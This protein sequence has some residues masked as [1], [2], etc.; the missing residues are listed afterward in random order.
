MYK[1]SSSKGKKPKYSTKKNS[2]GFSYQDLANWG[3][4]AASPGE[5]QAAIDSQVGAQIAGSMGAGVMPSVSGNPTIGHI[6]KN[7]PG[8][9]GPKMRTAPQV[10]MRPAPQIDPSG[11]GQNSGNLLDQL[12]QSMLSDSASNNFDYEAALQQSQNAIRQAYGAEIAAIRSNNNAARKDTRKARQE[13]EHMY[14]GLA[15]V[16]GQSAN[17]A[18]A[19]GNQGAQAA[20]DL[21]NQTNDAIVNENSKVTGQEA[22]ML[23]DLGLQATADQVI[24]PDYAKMKQVT[25]DVSKKGNE[26]AQFQK[27]QGTINRDYFQRGRTGVVFEGK[28][29]QA[30]LIAQLQDYLRQNRNQ[31]GTL[32]GQRAKELANNKLS[33]QQSIASQQAQADQQMWQRLMDYANLKSQIE[34]TNI[35]NTLAANK[36][37]WQQKMDVANLNKKGTSATKS[38]LPANLQKS[39]SI[40]ASNAQHPQA[41]ANALQTLF[42]SN[43]FKT[44]QKGGLNGQTYK[45]NQFEAAALAEQT[46][47]QLGLSVTDTNAL[48]LA[49]MASVG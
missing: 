44:G 15:A 4:H 49:A 1:S 8:G 45:L 10:T 46:A 33:V 43:E 5:I 16:Y 24:A 30:D 20:I 7:A 14:N 12:M 48:K 9:N 3:A 26:N 32:V 27:N 34:N 25:A 37:K 21:A 19:Q 39:F 2:A 40:V 41:V 36:F 17:H 38:N 42:A 11:G 22:Q 6:P 29:R 23:K 18:L 13:L 28:N 47:K 35:D 31:I